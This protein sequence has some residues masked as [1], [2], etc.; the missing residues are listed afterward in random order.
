MKEL[1]E[2]WVKIPG[3]KHDYEISNHGRFVNRSLKREPTNGYLDVYGYLRVSLV[4]KSGKTITKKVHRLVAEAFI[5]GFNNELSVN[6]ID[7]NKKN[8]HVSNLEMLSFADNALHYIE[9]IKKRDSTSCELGIGFHKG[10]G[11]WTARANYN[12][13]RYNL[14]VFNTEKEAILA[15]K[16]FLENPICDKLKIGKGQYKRYKGMYASKSN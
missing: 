15:R 13:K 1:I 16:S 3:C 4:L 6:H 14:G 7:F 10:I 11:K 9:N 5:S 2:E 8:N 12:G